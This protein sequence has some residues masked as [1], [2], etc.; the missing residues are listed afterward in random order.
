M[1][2]GEDKY[3]TQEIVE[4]SNSIPVPVVG[5]LNSLYLQIKKQSACP[6]VNRPVE[7]MRIITA[8]YSL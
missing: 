1:P 7:Q 3:K 8:G 4:T 5:Y 6:V 2:F